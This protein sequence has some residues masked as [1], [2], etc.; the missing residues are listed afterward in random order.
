MGTKFFDVDD[1]K[2]WYKGKEGVS[3]KS[4]RMIEQISRMFDLPADSKTALRR[5]SSG[6]EYQLSLSAS[7]SG[8]VRAPSSHSSV[9]SNEGEGS[10]S[11]APPASLESTTEDNEPLSAGNSSSSNFLSYEL[12]SI[13]L[14]KL[15]KVHG[16]Y[17][18]RFGSGIVVSE[19][20]SIVGQEQTENGSSELKASEDISHVSP[21]AQNSMEK[22]N[23]ERSTEKTMQ[24][25]KSGV[26][27]DF[28]SRLFKGDCVN[29]G[30]SVAG[31]SNS[32][33]V[34]VA[35]QE[36]IPVVV[37]LENA[38]DVSTSDFSDVSHEACQNAASTTQSDSDATKFDL[39][40]K[41]EPEVIYP[42]NNFIVID[43]VPDTHRYRL[44]TLQPQNQKTFVRQVQKEVTLMK[45]SLPSGIY[46]K[47]YEERMVSLT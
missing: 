32:T 34:P 15:L 43:A 9:P 21:A 33:S 29:G 26:F 6:S 25:Q 24:V 36:S 2:N 11:A 38:K 7:E 31:Q 22:A 46:V 41:M 39:R 3:S 35:V 28:F 20:C 23:C 10:E 42:Q 17:Q 1:L 5:L 12:C 18:N 4:R 19:E 45:N 16:E 13:I 27:K 37:S 8:L 30:T 40:E 44:T 14:N 47:S